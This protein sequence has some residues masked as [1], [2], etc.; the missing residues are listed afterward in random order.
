M[1][2]LLFKHVEQCHK[3]SITPF[4][5]VILISSGSFHHV[6]DLII[7]FNWLLLPFRNVRVLLVGAISVGVKPVRVI[8][9][10]VVTP[11]ELHRGVEPTCCLSYGLLGHTRVHGRGL[12]FGIL[13]DSQGGEKR[14]FPVHPG[15]C[16]FWY[17]NLFT[18]CHE[19]HWCLFSWIFISCFRRS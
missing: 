4:P 9:G 17:L 3:I 7:L 19:S 15:G 18:Q 5:L 13:I 12:P 10:G 11:P 14:N 6:S 2:L 1:N 8:S 16:I